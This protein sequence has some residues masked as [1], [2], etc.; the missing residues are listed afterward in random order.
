MAKSEA[1]NYILPLYKDRSLKHLVKLAGGKKHAKS[2]D[3]DQLRAMMIARDKIAEDMQFNAIKWFRPFPY[4][5][6]FFKTGKDFTRRGMIAANRSGK[7]VASAFE[8]AYHLTGMYPDWWDGKRWDKPIIAMATGESGNKLQ[9]R[10]SPKF[11]VVTTLS[12]PISWGLV[13][14]HGSK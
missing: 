4:Q 3:A 11:L 14:F 6:T 7:T 12:S 1:S 9:K 2:L 8:V 5:L 10:Y 13:Q